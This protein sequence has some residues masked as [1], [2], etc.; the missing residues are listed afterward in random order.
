VDAFHLARE[1]GGQ[2]DGGGDHAR[3]T[4]LHGAVWQLQA[5]GAKDDAADLDV[6]R[7]EALHDRVGQHL[8]LLRP[9][10]RRRAH[11]EHAVLEADGDGL[12]CD[13]RADG[14][15][16]DDEGHGRLL[17]RE[18]VLAGPREDRVDGLWAV[19]VRA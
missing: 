12:V 7:V 19:E 2:R 11:G 9:R 15:S 3:L 16:P 1:T 6:V 13:A 10:A 14:R 4:A 5:A 8:Q 17:R 18:P